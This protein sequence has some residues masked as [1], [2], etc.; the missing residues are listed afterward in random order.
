MTA[1]QKT[2]ATTAWAWVTALGA[3]WGLS[4]ASA[5]VS[6]AAGMNPVLFA[7]IETALISVIGCI[8]VLV[9]RTR[10]RIDAQRA[11]L[12]AVNGTLVVAIPYLVSYT[13]LTRLTAGE[14]TVVLSLAPVM[15]TILAILV[16][17]ERWNWW[18]PAGALTCLV[19]IATVALAASGP[20]GAG[21]SGIGHGWW[22]V[23]ATISPLCYAVAN[24][25]VVSR[26]QHTASEPVVNVLGTNV[27]GFL[28]LSIVLV[29]VA[30]AGSLRTDVIETGVALPFLALAALA[31]AA[32]NLLFFVAARVTSASVLALSG[33]LTTIFGVLFGIALAGEAWSWALIAG[34]SLVIAGVY[35]GTRSPR[36]AT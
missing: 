15:T 19:G 4:V 32:A 1:P 30:A 21:P 29:V 35:I 9:R 24:V 2:S 10:V 11:R 36:E 5:R 6:L 26:D 13:A 31:N 27:V 34:G 3:F 33:Y 8:V 18:V 17:V 25:Y 12:W 28:L 22:V 16:R 14:V 7:V 20:P 23:I